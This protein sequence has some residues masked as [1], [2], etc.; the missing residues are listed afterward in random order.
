MKAGDLAEFKKLLLERRQMLAG[1]VTRMEDEALRKSRQNASGD[2]SSMPYHMADIGTDNYEQEFTLGL[3]ENNEKILQ[4][5]DE[6][7]ERIKNG[8]FGTCTHCSALVSKARL[9][10]IPW[11]AY[12]IECQKIAEERGLDREN[13]EGNIEGNNEG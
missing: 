3:I 8:T 6:A 7:L 13:T 5:I 2:L 10:A 4:E 11:A 12:C 9:R 1:D